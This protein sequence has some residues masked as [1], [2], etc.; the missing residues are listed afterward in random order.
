MLASALSVRL[1]ALYTGCLAVACAGN[2][3]KGEGTQKSHILKIAPMTV[4]LWN[5]QS[6]Y[7]ITMVV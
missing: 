2:G 7:L 6:V 5:F 1:K 4:M 3:R